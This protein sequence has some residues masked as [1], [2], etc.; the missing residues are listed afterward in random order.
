MIPLKYDAT[1]DREVAKAAGLAQKKINWAYRI[2]GMEA[3]YYWVN[4]YLHMHF[5]PRAFQRYG[6]ARRSFR[7]NEKKARVNRAYSKNTGQWYDAPK[8]PAPMVWTGELREHV[9][10]RRNSYQ[11]K[12]TSKFASGDRKQV[13]NITLPIHLNHPIN[14]RNA[15]ELTR[16]APSEWRV[17]RGIVFQKAKKHLRALLESVVNPKKKVAA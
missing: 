4:N 9:L 3:A 16:L 5:E 11:A 12:A 6:Y 2:A 8:P 1:L 15:G 17:M 7:W 14:P 13:L 10:G